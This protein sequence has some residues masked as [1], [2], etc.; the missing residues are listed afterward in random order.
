M[1]TPKC[2]KHR[3]ATVLKNMRPRLHL[4]RKR[5]GA[6]RRLQPH[7]PRCTRDMCAR[8]RQRGAEIWSGEECFG[9]TR[10]ADTWARTMGSVLLALLLVGDL[11]E[12]FEV[13]LPVL[14]GVGVAEELLHLE[15][16]VLF[17]LFLLVLLV[18]SGTAAEYGSRSLR[19]SPPFRWGPA[20]KTQCS[21]NVPIS[22]SLHLPGWP[23]F[24]RNRA[25]LG[26]RR[27]KLDRLRAHVGRLWPISGNSWSQLE[28]I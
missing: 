9:T 15:L 27:D 28:N 5:V 23:K 14:V 26:Q 2:L 18:L 11:E 1:L 21:I 19:T 4:G 25:R 22:S 17:L 24:G 7:V 3:L 8:T 6:S 16:L 10:R 13:H 12:L 20:K